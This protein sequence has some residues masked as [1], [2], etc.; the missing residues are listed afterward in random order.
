MT[1]NAPARILRLTRIELFKLRR[2]RLAQAVVG[3]PA[4][5]ALLIPQGLWLSGREGV[6]GVLALSTAVELALLLVTFLGFLHA[7]VAVAWERSERTLRDVLAGPVRRSE[8]LLSRWIAL[9]LELALAVLLVLAAAGV[10]S[11]LH[12]RFE[13]I[14]GDAIEPLFYAGEVG[15]HAALGVAYFLPPAAALVTVGLLVSVLAATPAVAAAAGLGALL[16]LDIAKSLFSSTSGFVLGLLNAYLPSLFDRTSY[17]HGVTAMANGIGDVLW[18]DDA[19]Q[20]L[21]VLLV[22]GLYAGCAL[23]AALALFTRRDFTE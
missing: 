1:S 3:L 2:Q 16:C 21:L 6:Q 12:Y 23:A 5:A 8:V 4:A 13:D 20:H 17:L 10:S 9:E 11:L 15:R 7:S 19:P 22:P 18:A 14:R